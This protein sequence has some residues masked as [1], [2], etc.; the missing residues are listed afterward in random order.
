MRCNSKRNSF[1]DTLPHQRI[2]WIFLLTRRLLWAPAS[3]L[4]W[5]LLMLAAA[6]T[7]NA[8]HHFAFLQQH[9]QQQRNCCALSCVCVSIYCSWSEHFKCRCSPFDISDRIKLNLYYWKVCGVCWPAKRS[10]CIWLES[11]P[12]F[13]EY[14]SCVGLRICAFRACNF[15]PELWAL[16]HRL[17]AHEQQRAAYTFRASED[18]SNG[19]CTQ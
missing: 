19:I 2:S 17:A 11:T 18:V 5:L 1:G 8:F 12:H 4:G 15:I 16:C 6:P 9:R 10:N 7:Y 13:L 3:L 14:V